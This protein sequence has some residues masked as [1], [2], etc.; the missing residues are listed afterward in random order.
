MAEFTK[1]YALNIAHGAMLIS[2]RVNNKQPEATKEFEP[3]NL[4]TSSPAS[5]LGRLETCEGFLNQENPLDAQVIEKIRKHQS[6]MYSAQ[7]KLCRNYAESRALSLIAFA[8]S[9][10][11]K[12]CPDLTGAGVIL[13]VDGS[14]HLHPK[15]RDELSNHSVSNNSNTDTVEKK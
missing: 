13:A 11:K 6:E 7:K 1:N 12:E 10:L 5:M 4:L 2:E 15:Y 9:E 14:V 3:L 8:L